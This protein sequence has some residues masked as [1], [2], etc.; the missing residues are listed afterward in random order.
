MSLA[1]G[2]AEFSLEDMRRRSSA[3]GRRKAGQ[4]FIARNRAPRVQ[5][6]YDVEIYGAEKKIQLPFVMGVMADLV[7]QA[8]GAAAARRRAQ[9]PRDR[10]RQLR[11]PPQGD[12]AAGR[13]H[14]C[15]TRSP[16]RASCRSTSPSRAWTTSRPTRSPARSSRC[17]SCSRRAQQLS[18]PA[19]LHGRQG[20]RRGAGRQAPARPGAACRRWRRRRSRPTPPRRRPTTRP[21]EPKPAQGGQHGRPQTLEQAPRGAEA[22]AP[23]P[24]TSRRSQERSFRPRDQRAGGADRRRGRHAG[25]AGA[26][27]TRG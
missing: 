15:R 24:T 5:I 12:E 8:G 23:E 19:H 26:A 16:A 14:A 1:F 20:Q 7:G 22:E 13:L 17:A 6:E 9:V 18:Q 11:R 2:R 21:A 10:R 27:A 25:R 3:D 4:K